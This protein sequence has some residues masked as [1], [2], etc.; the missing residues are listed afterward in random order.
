MD[1][2]FT[3]SGNDFL[4]KLVGPHL[5]QVAISDCRCPSGIFAQ[6]SFDTIEKFCAFYNHQASQR[7]KGCLSDAAANI[8]INLHGIGTYETSF[9]KCCPKCP[10]GMIISGLDAI[11]K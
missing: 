7:A 8:L 6:N 5:L 9:G 4:C 11:K 2:D 1:E 3:K 10:S